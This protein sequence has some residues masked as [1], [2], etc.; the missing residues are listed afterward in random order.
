MHINHAKRE[1]VDAIITNQKSEIV[2]NVSVL[3]RTWNT[4]KINNEEIFVKN[5]NKKTYGKYNI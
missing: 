5:G 1:V 4:Y 2:I 3:T